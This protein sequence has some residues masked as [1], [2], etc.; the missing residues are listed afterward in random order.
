MRETEGRG[1]KDSLIL[2]SSKSSIVFFEFNLLKIKKNPTSHMTMLLAIRHPESAPQQPTPVP[3]IALTF[4]WYKF[5]ISLVLF[6]S[7]WM[8]HPPPISVGCSVCM[9]ISFVCVCTHLLGESFITKP[10]RASRV[11]W[12]ASYCC[13]KYHDLSQFRSSGGK[14]YFSLQV[15]MKESRART[16]GGMRRQKSRRKSS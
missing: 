14:G 6:Q 5:L 12:F 16:Q 3:G 10:I 4:S 8:F 1:W 7:D 13:G 15:I 9:L 2:N 11:S